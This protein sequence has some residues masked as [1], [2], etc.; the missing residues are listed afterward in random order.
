MSFVTEIA[1][2]IYAARRQQVAALN[3]S[4]RAG[5]DWEI[6]EAGK[7]YT[8]ACAA[9]RNA[10]RK[11]EKARATD[12]ADIILK[13]SVLIVGFKATD[14]D[15]LR[16]FRTI[17]ELTLGLIQRPTSRGQLS[18]SRIASRAKLPQAVV[19][20]AGGDSLAQYLDHAKV[21]LRHHAL[22]GE[23]ERRYMF[24]MLIRRSARPRRPS[25]MPTERSRAVAPLVLERSSRKPWC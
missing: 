23:E 17:E 25:A 4:E 2:R 8:A 12:Y 1:D 14:E 7:A 9:E 3:E 16:A 11:L 24:P 21:R 10:L 18:S 15:Y 13:A 5:G 20:A 22:H 6:S 19:S